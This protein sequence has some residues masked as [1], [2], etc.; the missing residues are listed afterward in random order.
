MSFGSRSSWPSG[1][2]SDAGRHVSRNADDPCV[3]MECYPSAG[4]AQ[5]RT[6]AAWTP[7]GDGR[8]AALPVSGRLRTKPRVPLARWVSGSPHR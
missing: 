7:C 2:G 1:P 6:S 3:C 4:Q 8:I 5:D